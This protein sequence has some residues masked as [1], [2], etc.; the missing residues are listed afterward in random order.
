MARERLNETY[1]IRKRDY[2][3]INTLSNPTIKKKLLETFGESTD[4]ASVHLKAAALPK[5]RWHVILPIDSLS[6][7][8]VFAPNY[9]KW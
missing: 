1:D 3:E 2:D 9:T 4:K 5:S 8:E 7:T 6:P